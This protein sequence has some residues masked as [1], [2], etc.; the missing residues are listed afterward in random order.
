PFHAA[1]DALVPVYRKSIRD[2]RH[3]SPRADIVAVGYGTYVPRE[4]CAAMGNATEA[5]LVF[6]QGMIDRLSDTIGKVA[7]QER[8]SFVDMRT[9]EGWQDHAACAAP[10]EQWI[11]G[12]TTYND[13]APLHPSTKGMAQMAEK[14]LE[15][16]TPL[17]TARRASERRVAKAASTVR[18]QAVCH[19]PKRHQRVTLRVTGGQ[20]LVAAAHF[21]IGSRS[22]GT[23]LRAPYLVTRSV[24]SLKSR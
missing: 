7:K 3:R 21:R 2:V 14:S 24:R 11:R 18:L 1:I 10:E 15:T 12:L 17:V 16:I 4:R 8:I 23:D 20:G 22:V 19:G 6:L 5:D 9:S 13:G